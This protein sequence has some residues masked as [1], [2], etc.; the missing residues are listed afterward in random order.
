MRY[1]D[2]LVPLGSCKCP[3]EPLSASALHDNPDRAFHL[4]LFAFCWRVSGAACFWAVFL[5]V[6]FGAL[7][8]PSVQAGW[9]VF[10]SHTK[11]FICLRYLDLAPVSGCLGRN[12]SLGTNL[13]SAS[14]QLPSGPS[15]SH[16][17]L[18]TPP[19]QLDL[20]AVSRSDFV[21]L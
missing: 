2:G 7:H 8:K 16:L 3:T 11:P 5:V 13:S 9:R 10:R 20:D 1:G 17:L 15:P 4:F 18:Q 19:T 14:S 21:L 6:T 12:I